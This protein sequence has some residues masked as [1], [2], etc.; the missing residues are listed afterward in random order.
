MPAST[1]FTRDQFLRGT[2]PDT[3]VAQRYAKSFHP[4]RSGDVLVATRPFFFWGK[5]AERDGGT[6]HGSPYDYDTHV[7]LVLVGPWFRGGVYGTRIDM[8]DLSATLCK[9]L[10]IPTPP[11]CEGRPIAPV[12]K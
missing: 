11:H 3:K 8:A 6:T 4:D 10:G 5:Y 1:F 7:P 2:L 9:V 12:L